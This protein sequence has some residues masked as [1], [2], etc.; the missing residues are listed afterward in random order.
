MRA[1]IGWFNVTWTPATALGLLLM[2]IVTQVGML[3]ALALSAAGSVAALVATFELPV[4]PGAHEPDEA[5]AAVGREYPFLVRAA[6]WLLP[7]SYIL[8]SAC[9]RCCR[10]GSRRSAAG[11]RAAA[12]RHCGWSLA[13]SRCWRCGVRGSGTGAG[14]RWRWRGGA[15]GGL[16]AMML[17]P[18]VAVL[19]AGLVVFGVGMGLTYY[20]AL[21]YSLAVGRAAVDAGGTFEALIGFGYFAG[22]LV[23][24]GA[25]G[26]L[27]RHAGCDRRLA[28]W[29]PRVVPWARWTLPAARRSRSRSRA[30]RGLA[31]T[32]KHSR[33]PRLRRGATNAA[34][35]PSGAARRSRGCQVAGTDRQRR[36]RALQEA[37]ALA[38][39]EIGEQDRGQ[40]DACRAQ[41]PQDE[42]ALRFGQAPPLPSSEVAGRRRRARRR[43][44]RAACGESRGPAAAR[45]RRRR[46]RAHWRSRAR[47]RTRNRR[48]GS[49]V[50]RSRY[51]RAVL[52]DDEARPRRHSG[53]HAP[54]T[55]VNGSASG[56]TTRCPRHS[57][58]RSRTIASPRPLSRASI[59]SS[60]S[61][62]V[63]ESPSDQAH[64]LAAR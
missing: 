61:V 46:R 36:Q 29:W 12:S 42:D 41:L 17:A 14:G 3:A 16:A 31:A 5:Q 4:R 19:A 28:G 30:K 62:A 9:R 38:V 25:R 35:T 59:A 43:A 44:A 63:A 2:P 1:A 6:S 52:A 60:V 7:M 40:R 58:T 10:I 22:P 57:R 64:L 18:S 45:R 27:A 47:A 39:V 24:L 32:W 15:G 51:S 55:L 26:S 48:P 53:K 34:S 23:G 54:T 33:T 56:R 49:G 50:K 37:R 21:Y 13:S 8:C 20:A 11:P